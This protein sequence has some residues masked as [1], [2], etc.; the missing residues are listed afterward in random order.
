MIN[1][2]HMSQTNHILPLSLPLHPSAGQAATRHPFLISRLAAY[3][4]V[5]IVI[6]SLVDMATARRSTIEIGSW[7]GSRGVMMVLGRGWGKSK[8]DRYYSP[9]EEYQE[10]VCVWGGWGMGGGVKK[11]ERKKERKEKKAGQGGRGEI[12]PYLSIVSRCI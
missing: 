3:R 10:C 5:A 12:S 8:R 6:C 9:R 4:P 7:K 1:A 11:K 2:I